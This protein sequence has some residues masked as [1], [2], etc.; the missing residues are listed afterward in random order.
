[1]H[2]RIQKLESLVV[3]LM[4]RAPAGHSGKEPSVIPGPPSPLLT[5][6]NPSTSTSTV[7]LPDNASS[8]FDRGSLQWSNSGGSYVNSS[9]WAA[10]LDG[11][12]ELKDH[13]EKDE[14]LQ[15]SN[16]PSDSTLP[17]WTGPQ[18]LQGCTRFAAKDEILCSIPMRPAVD[19]LVSRYFSSFEVSPGEYTVR[20]KR[21]QN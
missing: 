9:H 21:V 10:I 8:I 16:P 19:R 17:D 11:I 1:M 2:D 14:E 7:D 5:A 18:L 12:A 4:Q 6:D 20:G 3:D 15:E 13:F